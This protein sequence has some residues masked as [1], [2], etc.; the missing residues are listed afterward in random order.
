MLASP[1]FVPGAEGTAGLTGLAQ[2]GVTVSVLTIKAREA[3]S[4]R[5]RRD[6]AACNH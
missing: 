2:R 3:S 6:S 5:A 1:Y 4:F